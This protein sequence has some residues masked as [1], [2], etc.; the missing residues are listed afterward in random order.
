MFLNSRT[1]HKKLLRD[2]F[3]TEKKSSLR[4]ISSARSR[5]LVATISQPSDQIR[6]NI[7]E[8]LLTVFMPH[9][10]CEQYIRQAA[11]SVLQQSY[12]NFRLVIVD[13]ASP[14]DAWIE[15]LRP[16]LKDPRIS[17]FHSTENVG[18]YRLFNRILPHITTPW[19]AFHDSDDLSHPDR[20]KLQLHYGKRTQADIVC[21]N[22]YRTTENGDVISSHNLAV[23]ANRQLDRGRKFVGLHSTIMAKRVVFEAL[24]GFDGTTRFGAD[25]EFLLRAAR[26][27]RIRNLRRYL[28]YYRQRSTSLTGQGDTGI[29]SPARRAYGYTVYKRNYRWQQI[30]TTATLMRAL[31]A[32]PNNVDFRLHPVTVDA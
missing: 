13:D 31:R 22:F 21:C 19:I 29:G 18:P 9:Y 23:D 15:T 17:L 24:K 1:H 8:P 6:M 3:L 11:E 4:I 5:G 26:L 25:T 27:Y 32:A 2:R 16:V 7:H 20:F 14:T 28:Y 10:R 12:R 30:R